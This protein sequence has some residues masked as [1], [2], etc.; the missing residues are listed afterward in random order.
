MQTPQPKEIYTD[1]R[2]RFE[3][4]MRR[5]FEKSGVDLDRTKAGMYKCK[6][7]QLWWLG[8]KLAHESEN[9]INRSSPVP[10]T[11]FIVGR[12]EDDNGTK[13]FRLAPVPYRHLTR[14][15]ATEEANRLANFHGGQFAI[16][17]C[18]DIVSPVKEA[19]DG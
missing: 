3:A 1:L 12:V 9:G 8:Y 13:K 15:N 18:V 16:F 14:L 5:K 19:I 10:A 6:R 7:I 11:R 2:L 4:D 17:R